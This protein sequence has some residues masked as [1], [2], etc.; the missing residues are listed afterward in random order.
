MT[1]NDRDAWGE[2][3]TRVIV[4]RI[5]GLET[6]LDDETGQPLEDQ[7]GNPVYS[8]Q[9]RI[10][11]QGRSGT[12]DK[13]PCVFPAVGNSLFVGAI[14]EVGTRCIVMWREQ[15]QPVIIGFIPP[16][17]IGL[18]G[19]RRTL[20]NLAPGEVLLQASARDFDEAEDENF[21]RGARVWLDRLGRIRIEAQD[22][23]FLVGYKLESE[24]GPDP[25]LIDD[26]VTGQSIFFRERIL[27]NE[28]RVD[29]DGNQFRAVAGDDVKEV[30]GA[31]SHTFA[32]EVTIAVEQSYTVQDKRGNSFGIAADGTLQMTA[33]AKMVLTSN[34]SM[35][36]QV[37][38]PKTTMVQDDY[39][40][41]IGGTLSAMAIADLKLTAAK[42][43]KM[44]SFL[45]SSEKIVA[46]GKTIDVLAGGFG[47]TVGEGDIDLAPVSGN[48][49]LGL[50]AGV[51][52]GPAV[53]GDVLVAALTVLSQAV[54]AAGPGFTPAAGGGGPAIAAAFQAFVAVLQGGPLASGILSHNVKVGR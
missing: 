18:V 36:D 46:G 34:G 11:L 3:G 54:A 23:E 25:K 48:V 27:H 49:N 9:F 41:A 53:L 22:Y 51:T 50:G 24:F 8:G 40:M 19:S 7:D 20:P 28:R 30:G 13:V 15:D 37:A 14:P 33:A 4:A 17:L 42:Q 43:I 31:T 10:E 12:Y 2:F 35:D 29:S 52:G 26:P 44:Q 32:G 45:G 5:V 38:G 39:Q 1:D 21:F 16:S 47:V 6:V